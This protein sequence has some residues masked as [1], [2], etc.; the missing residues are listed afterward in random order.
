MPLLAR[1]QSLLLLALA[2]AATAA[3]ARRFR[4]HHGLPLFGAPAPAA[5]G[6]GDPARATLRA[7]PAG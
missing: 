1:L 2:A 4:T 3:Y 7:G 5:G 6:I